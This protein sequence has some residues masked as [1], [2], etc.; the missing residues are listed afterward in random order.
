MH[1]RRC[2][3]RSLI[4]A[5]LLGTLSTIA[6]AQESAKP[7][8]PAGDAKDAP[9]KKWDVNNPPGEKATVNL[10]TKTGTWMSVDVSPD[11]KQIVFDLLGDLY[12]MP[13]E[14]GAAKPLTSTMA[15]EMQARFSPDGKRLTYMSDAGGGDN[16][17]IMNVD[18]SNARE[19]S[20]ETYRM[21]NNPV[22]HPNG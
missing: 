17:W 20:K 18:G 6:I 3:L 10:D 21:M 8:A 4:C 13:I 16:V 11:G 1:N 22:W 5:S 14:G 2:L 19:V 7:V 15:W 9:K 12:I